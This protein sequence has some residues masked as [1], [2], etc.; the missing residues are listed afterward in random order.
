M[1]VHDFSGARIACALLG[2]NS[3]SGDDDDG[4]GGCVR[5]TQSFSYSLA[6]VDMA[7]DSGAGASPN[8]C[9]IHIHSGSSCATDAAGHYFVDPVS[10]DP[11]TS[12]GYTSTAGAASS[13]VSVDTGGAESDLKGR[14]VIVHDFS[15]ARIACALLTRSGDGSS[16]EGA[17]DDGGNDDDAQS[18]VA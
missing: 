7:C 1:I 15:G 13:T 12:I 11:W 9:G 17:N 4:G 10:S 5:T 14:A 18:A 3:N 16:S 2:D 8:S 6:G